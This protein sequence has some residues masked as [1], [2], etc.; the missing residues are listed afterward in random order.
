MEAIAQGFIQFPQLRRSTIALTVDWAE[1][2]KLNLYAIAVCKD[3][4][5]RRMDGSDRLF[6]TDKLCHLF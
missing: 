2:A 3:T 6:P 5:G 4:I 1:A